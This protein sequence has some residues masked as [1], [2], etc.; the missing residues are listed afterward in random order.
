M[1][2]PVLAWLGQTEAE[3]LRVCEERQLACCFERTRDPRQAAEA[4]G[5]WRV[6]RCRERE[7]RL[8]F[9]LGFF[10]PSGIK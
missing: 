7:D 2:N 8:C 10:A 1:D 4:P 5:T 3:C 9:L 6:I